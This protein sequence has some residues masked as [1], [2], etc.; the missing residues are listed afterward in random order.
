MPDTECNAKHG[1]CSAEFNI[2]VRRPRSIDTTVDISEPVNPTGQIPIVIPGADG[3][4][5]AVFTPVEG[6]SVK[7]GSCTFEAPSGAINDNEFI[8]IAVQTTDDPTQLTPVDDP[9]FVTH[10][11]QCNLSAVDNAGTNIADY[12]L[13]VAGDVCIPLPDEY[14]SNAFDIR[15]LS[16]DNGQTQILATRVIINDPGIPLKLCGKLSTLPNTVAAALPAN[17]AAKIPTPAPDTG[18]DEITIPD[19][20][21]S[22]IPPMATWFILV[23]GIALLVFVTTVKLKNHTSRRSRR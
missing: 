6:G 1:T 7:S 4:Q 9:R 19:T 10:D 8:G 5:H 23:L 16:V 13:R 3:T 17:L 20:G 18:N 22:A 14:R 21:P 15:L 12:R 2:R 11:S